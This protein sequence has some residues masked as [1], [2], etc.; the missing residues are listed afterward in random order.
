[1]KSSTAEQ[2]R[3]PSVVFRATTT[4]AANTFAWQM[5]GQINLSF[6]KGAFARLELPCSISFN[7]ISMAFGIGVAIPEIRIF[8]GA[9]RRI[10]APT[11][12]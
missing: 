4:R 8:L 6:F 2:P 10:S 1:M 7:P 11:A 5:E 9:S 3:G 12:R